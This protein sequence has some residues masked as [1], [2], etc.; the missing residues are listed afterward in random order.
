MNKNNYFSDITEL[1]LDAKKR[2][3]IQVNPHSKAATR[4]MLSY[5]IDQMKASPLSSPKEAGFWSKWKKQLIGVPASFLAVFAIVLAMQNMQISM[6]TQDF[7]PTTT[8]DEQTFEEDTAI[9]EDAQP[10]EEREIKEIQEKE[11]EP[12]VIDYSKASQ[13][14]ST[15]P[16]VETQKILPTY[17]PLSV[18]K[19]NDT[20]AEPVET[21]KL[22]TQSAQS[23]PVDDPSPEPAVTAAPEPQPEPEPTYT[24]QYIQAD[25]PAPTEEAKIPEPQPEPAT[26]TEP[27]IIPQA[28]EISTETVH[29]LMQDDILIEKEDELTHYRTPISST[30]PT[31]DINALEKIEN[32]DNLSNVNV[33]YL[34]GEQAAVE[35]ITGNETRWYM[36]EEL[37]GTWTVTQKF[38]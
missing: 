12:L 21:E 6:P 4:E 30:E 28:T 8:P 7:T 10:F 20:P 29:E 13:G 17:Q 22:T 38:D 24:P 32:P 37:N 16:V 14:S 23:W 27:V 11:I 19:V 15:Q 26:V 9:I 34:N 31:F 2:E 5:K 1:F 35:V 33:H 36:F 18:P 3:D 25:A